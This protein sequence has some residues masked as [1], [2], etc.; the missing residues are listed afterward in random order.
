MTKNPEQWWRRRA[1]AV[2]RQV[3]AGWWCQEFFPSL[4]VLSAAAGAVVL[5]LRG[6]GLPF[7]AAVRL[8]GLAVAS[9]AAVC[10]LRSLRR[11]YGAEDAL[12]QLDRLHGLSCGLPAAAAGI[13][14]WPAPAHPS[15][16]VFRWRWDRILW[17]PLLS[18]AWWA[19]A[20]WAPVE[21]EAAAPARELAPPAAWE[22]AQTWLEILAESEV[23]DEAGLQPFEAALRRLRTQPMEAWYNHGSLEAADSLQQR[24]ESAIERLALDL[25]S[26]R[27]AVEAAGAAAEAEGGVRPGAGKG[28]AVEAAGRLA[29]G[30][31]RLNPD[32]VR[33]LEQVEFTPSAFES[34]GTASKL[35]QALEQG[36]AACR[37]CTGPG[38][39][40]GAVAHR[41]SRPSAGAPL[42]GPGTAPLRLG[43][44]SEQTPSSRAEP[45]PPGGP[46][47]VALGDTL[48]VK[49]TAHPIEEDRV[50]PPDPPDTIAALGRGGQ[51][52]WRDR[53]TPT[54]QA[55]LQRFFE[56]TDHRP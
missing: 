35:Q 24:L 43:A 29:G 47:R 7:G 23:I 3:R 11:P 28:Q 48:A 13:R 53:L 9:A 31:L 10:L 4:L 41:G 6:A 55:V 33:A 37:A 32:L 45:M 34:G 40:A 14:S 19:G 39:A 51:A 30:T 5:G 52:V 12:A 56:S 50:P 42:R 17:F 20:L 15:R 22:T 16:P 21:P 36:L 2:V 44:P 38:D 26:A 8:Y 18:Q 1:A 49:E 25:H 46:E 54:E 27:Q